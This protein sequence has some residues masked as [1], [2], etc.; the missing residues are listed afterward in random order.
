MKCIALV[1]PTASG[2]TAL[3]I[4]LAKQYGGE[5]LS[6]DSMQIYRGMD[7]G[8]AKA[9]KDEQRE[10]P[11]HLIDIL[12]PSTPFSAADYADAAMDIVREVCARDA[13]PLFCGGTGLYLDAVRTLRHTGDTP[14]ADPTL[15]E[16]LQ[17]EAGS[18]AGRQALWQT[19]HKIDPTAA[20]ATHYN[21]TRRVIRALEVY[22]TTGKTKTALDMAA[23]VEN[24]EVEMLTLGLC[25][26]NRATLNDRIE[27][28]VDQML[29][30]G[31]L[32]ETKRLLEAGMLEEGYT[33]AAAIGYKELLGYL[34]GECT[35]AEATEALKTASRRY[36]K[37]QMTYFKR[38]EAIIW[39]TVDKDGTI[40]DT[41]SLLKEAMMYID[42]F[43]TQ[44]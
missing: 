36:A 38:N 9:T 40:R 1:G 31:L 19:L 43:L 17:R 8:T 14:A 25:F 37:R 23:N 4:A 10:V 6:C 29:E 15:R 13:L 28:R 3:S 18:E 20:E 2:K 39:L 22:Y 35:L 27:K 30:N 16:K 11:H 42:P 12:D 34:R 5:I 24:P 21:N 44:Q 41:D 32:D 7:I 33:A 26:A